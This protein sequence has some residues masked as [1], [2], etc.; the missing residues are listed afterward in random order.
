MTSAVNKLVVSTLRETKAG[1]RWLAILEQS[2]VWVPRDAFAAWEQIEAFAAWDQAPGSSTAVQDVRGA[3]PVADMN[4]AYRRNVEAFLWRKAKGIAASQA[5]MELEMEFAGMGDRALDSACAHDQMWMHR[6][7]DENARR[8]WFED[9]PL[10]RALRAPEA[11][12]TTA[13][14]SKRKGVKRKHPKHD[15]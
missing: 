9:L 11:P 15:D 1:R 7:T 5:T 2:D 12:T 8:A 13:K 4:L 6:A 10:V 14:K 3:I